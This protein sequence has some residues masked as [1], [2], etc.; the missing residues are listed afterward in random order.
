MLNLPALNFISLFQHLL[1]T[2]KRVRGDV[3]K[4][5]HDLI[6]EQIINL[7]IFAGVSN[8]GIYIIL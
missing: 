3:T 4:T 7:F 8:L 1:Q 6:F 2:P 5:A